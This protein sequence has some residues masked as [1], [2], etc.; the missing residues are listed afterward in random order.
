MRE[1]APLPLSLPYD[2]VHM[3][4]LGHLTDYHPPRSPAP[5]HKF[6]VQ[7]SGL[8]YSCTPTPPARR[9]RDGTHK[10][11]YCYISVEDALAARDDEHGHQSKD[12]DVQVAAPL[13]I[14]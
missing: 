4:A 11:N 10:T 13:E 7:R 8:D 5:V 1:R 9:R 6:T 12:S 3:P 14:S 2:H